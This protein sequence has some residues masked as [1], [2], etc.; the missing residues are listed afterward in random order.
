MWLKQVRVVNFRSIEN[1]TFKF[2]PGVNAI[3]GA[4]GTGKTNLTRAILRLLGP[5]YP[6]QNSFSVE[7]HTRRDESRLIEIELL[8][9]ANGTE[10]TISWKPYRGGGTRLHLDG[11]PY[12]NNRDREAFCPLHFPSNR[13]VIEF[14][15][16]NKW[17]P[18][19]RIIEELADVVAQNGAF[20][21]DFERRVIDL[22]RS[23]EAVPDYKTF[24]EKLVK[25]SKDQLGARGDAIDVRVGL[26]DPRHILKTLQVFEA[27]GTA[28]YNVADG[29]QGVQSSVTIAALRA[30]ASL[31][32][33]RFFVIADEP[34]AYLH[35]LAQRALAL[36]FEELARE[37][38]QVILTTH[39]PHFISADHIDGLHKVWMDGNRTK[40]SP[41]D[42][43]RLLQRRVDRGTE[44]GTSE[45]VKS[46]LSKA[47]TLEA[48]EALFAQLAVICEG[49]TESLSLPIWA[50]YDGHDFSKLGIAV[51]QSQG[52]FS[53]ISLSEFYSSFNLPT[54]LVF[55]S[56]SDARPSERAKHAEHN[57]W[58]LGFSGGVI[59]DFPATGVC[60]SHAIL[61]PNYESAVRVDP[62]YPR[63]EAEVND[64]LGLHGGSSK[65]VRAR[66]VALRYKETNLPPPSIIQSIVQAIVSC[67]QSAQ[68]SR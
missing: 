14:P 48:R 68:V 13:S 24:R 53:M 49:E 44:R 34:E 10:R 27:D 18:I 17:N 36:V 41:F 50:G 42:M 63:F 38:T 40:A 43:D 39:S 22:N 7:D 30:F 59:E 16:Q 67:R 28:Q 9:D 21:A 29:G 37:G 65:G 62:E 57:R 31:S 26:V 64:E 33:G 20:M 3:F 35:P 5:T 46:R 56:D 61:S 8:F 55:D 11:N 15:G 25:Y 54:Y 45:G 66:A 6:G 58:L 51:V 23:L 1:G 12:V 60:P 32:G 47:L 4:N 19:G 52:K 2:A